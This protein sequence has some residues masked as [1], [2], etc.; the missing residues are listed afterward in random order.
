MKYLKEDC[1][2]LQFLAVVKKCR[3]DVYLTT[4]EGDHLNLKSR[5]CQYIFAFASRSD[6]SDALLKNAVIECSCSQDYILLSDYL[7][8]S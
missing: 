8:E 3:D 2:I 7:S 4:A 1:D 5:L 6:A